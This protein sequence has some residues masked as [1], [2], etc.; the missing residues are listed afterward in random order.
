MSECYGG[1]GM[2]VPGGVPPKNPIADPDSVSWDL[3]MLS[4]EMPLTKPDGS[5]WDVDALGWSPPDPFV[6]VMAGA[7]TGQTESPED[8]FKPPW[9]AKVLTAVTAQSLRDGITFKVWDEDVLDDDFVGT[10]HFE[11]SNDTFNAEYLTA[12][13]DSPGLKVHFY[14]KPTS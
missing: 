6:V 8:V 14:T 11:M 4:G 12:S 10:C 1:Y 2:G 13:C 5:D 9:H 3:Y 7:E